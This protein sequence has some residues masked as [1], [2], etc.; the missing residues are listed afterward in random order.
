MVVEMG[1]FNCKPHGKL[2][3]SRFC[4]VFNEHL[5]LNCKL[6]M[7]KTVNTFRKLED[8]EEEI[9]TETALQPHCHVTIKS[10]KEV[11]ICYIF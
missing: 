7:K 11:G 6:N 10:S 9:D 4:H 2:N 8:S 5:L 1:V 3:Y